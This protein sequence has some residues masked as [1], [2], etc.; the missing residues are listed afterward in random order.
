MQ[1]L[2]GQEKGVRSMSRNCEL[3]CANIEVS[4]VHDF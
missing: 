1:F 4:G 3:S 2:P